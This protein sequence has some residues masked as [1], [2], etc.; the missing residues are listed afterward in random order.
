MVV[1]DTNLDGDSEWSVGEVLL[2]A[3][4]ND[5][6]DELVNRVDYGSKKH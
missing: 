6:F 4:L 5:T 1:R 2:A 3:D